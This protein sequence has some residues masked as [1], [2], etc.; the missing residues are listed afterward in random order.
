MNL[1]TQ[2]LITY[3]FLTVIIATGMAIYCTSCK[4]EFSGNE[5]ENEEVVVKEDIT[6]TCTLISDRI[7]N[8]NLP[9][10]ISA[11][12]ANVAQWLGILG[13]DGAFS[14]I[15]YTSKDND[16]RPKEHLDRLKE[17]AQAYI[18][19]GSTYHASDDLFARIIKALEYW[20]EVHPVCD[21]W[22]HNQ[23]SS[24]QTIGEILILL[25]HGSKQVPQELETSILD[26]MER[27]GGD[28]S[29][30][31]GANETDIA[32]HWLYRGCLTGDSEILTK[33]VFHS[34][35]PLDA[36][37]SDNVGLQH[38]MSFFQ[39]GPQLYI[40]GYGLT[41]I[42]GVT[43]VATYVEGTDYNMTKNQLYSLYRFVSDTYCGSMRGKMLF[44]NV[45]GR[46]VS[47]PGALK[48][49]GFTEVLEAMKTIDPEHKADYDMRIANITD[50]IY[51]KRILK[52]YYVGD[53]FSIEDPAFSA[54]VRLS[55]ERTRRCEN[56]NGENLYGYFMSDGSTVVSVSGDEYND[57]FPSWNWSR[58]P[59][60][61]NP[62]ID[63]ANL[64]LATE[65]GELGESD[66]AGGITDG[67][68]G[69]A[70]L[71]VVYNRQDVDMEANKSYYFIDDKI[72][73]L[74]SGITS[75]MIQWEGKDVS[76]N[77]TVES[78]LTNGDVKYNE[79]GAI[80]TLSKGSTYTKAGINWIYH[81]S[82]GYFILND[83]NQKVSVKRKKQSGSWNAINSTQ[84]E[85]NV[86]H[87][88][89][90]VWF[91]HGKQP[92][93]AKYA[94]MI[95]PGITESAMSS[96]NSNIEI[97]YNETDIHAV[98][99]T[100]DNT[101]SIVFFNAGTMQADDLTI[102]ADKPC[103]LML[104]EA[105]TDQLNLY[106]SDPTHKLGTLNLEITRNGSTVNL[107]LSDFAAD[108]AHRG[109][110]HNTLINF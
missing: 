109:R 9:S 99:D 6:E 28:P 79:N 37:N 44:Y 77:T 75:S 82:I 96:Y 80:K 89:F 15:D 67:K 65:W 81:K 38:D 72:V 47:R 68:N 83:Y 40:G 4:D 21:N 5:E 110:T 45:M 59:G 98:K 64:P 74:G 52:Q 102:K 103:A 106:Y 8:D 29:E 92:E 34:F 25:R 60:V 91:D 19:E 57:V 93:N 35:R 86:D 70:A 48:C 36:V 14:D 49:G 32:L 62:Y 20:N 78:N 66:F 41:M 76:I 69:L 26:Y 13:D 50:N 43:K 7:K 85:A 10:D 55:S 18:T 46:S 31:S 63:P 56:G 53:Y 88:V 95:V 17:I 27:T 105:G 54:G 61:T 24:P 58:I 3:R 33:A 108:N 1:K 39:H 12:D 16:W 100:Q 2:K 42:N 71:K 84:S 94:Y 107:Q 51:T 11:T 104:Q 22:Y 101:V 73:C 90:T 23:I 87:D 97:L 30:Q